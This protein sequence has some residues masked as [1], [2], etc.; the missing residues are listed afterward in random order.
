M[1]A[2]YTASWS[3][4][5]TK[6]PVPSVPLASPLTNKWIVALQTVGIGRTERGTTIDPR[7]NISS[8]RPAYHPLGQPFSIWQLRADKYIYDRT[9]QHTS[10]Y[11]GS[12][13]HT[14]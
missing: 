13:S 6:R 2:P 9:A 5:Q 14:R 10:Y 3:V 8:H 12:G 11:I 4:C 7:T 1:T